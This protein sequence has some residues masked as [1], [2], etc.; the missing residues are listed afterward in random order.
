VGSRGSLGAGLI[1]LSSG[2]KKESV[3]V[4]NRRPLWPKCVLAAHLAVFL[5]TGYGLALTR[6]DLFR[7]VLTLISGTSLFVL[8]NL[9]HT[10]SHYHLA[11]QPWLNDLL[12][13]LAGALLA[14]P[15]S[16]YRALHMKHHQ[17]ANRDD[18]PFLALNSRWM[19]LFGTP[20]A[21]AVIHGYALRHLRGWALA[22]YLI[23][24]SAIFTLLAS[25][26]LL[27]RPVR[28][29]SLFGPLIVV[30][31]LHNIQNVFG[32]LDL[33]AGKYHDTWQLVLPRWISVWMLNFD[34]HLEHHICPRLHWYELPEFRA[35]L[36]SRPE[37]ELHRVTLL[38]FYIEVFLRRSDRPLH[39]RRSIMRLV[40]TQVSSVLR[41]F[42]TRPTPGLVLASDAA[43]PEAP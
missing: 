22:R 30:A 21:V 36:S 43:N 18:D 37:L 28:E 41:G 1:E 33:P 40:A 12:G 25:L 8:T 10:A 5:L 34:H 24:T 9:I 38:E 31:I 23:E 15:V 39:R 2:K 29:W 32:H 20:T 42:G 13:N 27:P 14:T 17:A 19:I 26:F 7:V 35:K 3:A 4:S 11:R 16:A 6:S